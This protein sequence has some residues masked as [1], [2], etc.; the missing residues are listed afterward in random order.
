VFNLREK[1]AT[2]DVQVGSETPRFVN[3]GK[4]SWPTSLINWYGSNV[5][6]GGSIPWAFV[7][8]DIADAVVSVELLFR[9][10]HR[11][12]QQWQAGTHAELMTAYKAR[13]QEYDEKL[14]SMMRSLLGRSSRKA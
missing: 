13:M 7:T 4:W 12:I 14:A 6:S 11:R 8:H 2:I 10:T 5:A 3:G 9:I 1:N